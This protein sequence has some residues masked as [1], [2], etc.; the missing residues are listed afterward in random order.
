MATKKKAKKKSV[1]KVTEEIETKA[2]NKG[3]IDAAKAKVAELKKV[4]PNNNRYHRAVKELE[5]CQ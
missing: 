2:I 3:A 4:N 5:K 1:K